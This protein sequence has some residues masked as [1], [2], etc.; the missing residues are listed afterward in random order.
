MTDDATNATPTPEDP[1]KDQPESQEPTTV[2]P[3]ESQ[4]APENRDED[5]VNSLDTPPANEAEV[6]EA[7]DPPDEDELAKARVEAIEAAS[8]EAGKHVV[9]DVPVAP[10]NPGP[11]GEQV[12]NPSR[13]ELGSDPDA[14]TRDDT[15]DEGL[16]AQVEDE[17]AAAAARD[18]A[19]KAEAVEA[20]RAAREENE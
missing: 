1:T 10:S 3:D 13:P 17:R 2:A 12:A 16:A 4:P 11:D 14:D 9:A 19:A 5:Q 7:T 6:P 18:E 20:E 8:A 15:H